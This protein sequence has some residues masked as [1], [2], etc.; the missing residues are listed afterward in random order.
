MIFILLILINE[1]FKQIFPTYSKPFNKESISHSLKYI[2]IPRICERSKL[3]SCQIIHFPLLVHTS[4]KN[5][6]SDSFDVYFMKTQSLH[7]DDRK[8][9]QQQQK[10]NFGMCMLGWLEWS[11][12]SVSPFNV[13]CGGVKG[14]LPTFVGSHCG[15]RW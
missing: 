9:A 2:F 4:I 8:K 5:I 14:V 10:W 3:K 15:R 7:D 1:C 6:S 11:V 13:R 12:F